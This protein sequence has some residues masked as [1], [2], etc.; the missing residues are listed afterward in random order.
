MCLS[1][2]RQRHLI[3]SDDVA[4]LRKSPY[5]EFLNRRHEP[6]LD[7]F[8]EASVEDQDYINWN[9]YVLPYD[10]GDAEFEYHA[11]RNSCA[12][13]DVTPMC[14]IRVRGA[15]AGHFLDHLVTRPVSQLEPMRTT[16]TV[17][18]NKD[19]SLKDDS[20]LYKIADD[21]YVMMPSDIDHTAY[22]ESLRDSLGITE[23]TFEECT[24]D[25]C[26]LA[27]QGPRSAAV[28]QQMGFDSAQELAPF[29]VRDYQRE[30]RTLRVAR[31]GF[32]ADLGYEMWCEPDVADMVMDLVRTARKA[33]NLELPGY[34]LSVIDTCRM[35]GGFVVAAW[36]FATELDPE[37]ELERSPFEVGLGWLVNLDACAF[38]GRDA[39][40][41]EREHGSRFAFRTFS[42]DGKLKLDERAE[43]FSGPGSDR[44]AIGITTSSC[45]SWGLEKTIGNA[46][47]D[48]KFQ[49][50][51]TA[52]LLSGDQWI[53]MTLRQ[54]PLLALSHR[55]QVPA[56]TE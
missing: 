32:T 20:V 17:Y 45:W 31:M 39:L 53:E 33:L 37:P 52:W 50:L 15:N 30:G 7:A 41:K 51:E 8:M 19:G 23:V 24:D 44:T 13:C 14:M 46:S 25:W 42:L 6:G 9:Q 49:D 36:D 2:N 18:C 21:D 56:P 1:T 16:Y 34:A 5:F 47:I 26:G 35:E 28:M 48:S 3:R 22:F 27:I 29:E 12:L 10:Y 38:P 4:K 11:L 55:N 40:R 54:G 43:L